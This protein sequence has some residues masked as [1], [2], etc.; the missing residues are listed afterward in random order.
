LVLEAG[1]SVFVEECH[2]T[3]MTGVRASGLGCATRGGLR[4][5]QQPPQT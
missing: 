5:R 3:V 2:F 1:V 4:E